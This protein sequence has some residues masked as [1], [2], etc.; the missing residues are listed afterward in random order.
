MSREVYYLCQKCHSV[1]YHFDGPCDDR[2]MKI[3][4]PELDAERYRKALEEILTH[5]EDR[6]VFDGCTAHEIARRALEEK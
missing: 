2:P 6:C 4:V 5:C 3:L 1:L